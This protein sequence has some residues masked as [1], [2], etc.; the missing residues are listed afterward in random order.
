MVHILQ[1]QPQ[2]LNSDVKCYVT[3]HKL[4]FLQ[5]IFVAGEL[6]HTPLPLNCPVP[7]SLNKHQLKGIPESSLSLGTFFIHLPS[8]SV[9]NEN[10][11]FN[12]EFDN[13]GAKQISFKGM[14][15]A[16]G[17][18]TGK[19]ILLDLEF[20]TSSP[21]LELTDSKGKPINSVEG[22]WKVG[23]V[24]VV[25]NGMPQ[26]ADTLDTSVGFKRTTPHTGLNAVSVVWL[27]SG[28]NIFEGVGSGG[29]FGFLSLSDMAHPNRANA[30]NAA[31]FSKQFVFFDS[32]IPFAEQIQR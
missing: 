14:E 15:I 10:T 24:N 2:L 25:F 20:R 13:M 28:V 9:L 29:D 31:H 26:V 30:G 11:I 5:A 7:D 16:S 3:P 18:Y 19:L 17:R 12:Q 1:K 23:V 8:Q 22:L 6:R 21:T 4:N 32:Q 27:G